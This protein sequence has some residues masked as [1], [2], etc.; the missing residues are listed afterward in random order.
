MST[1]YHYPSQLELI[2]YPHPV[3]RKEA[4]PVEV[5][6]DDLAAFCKRMLAAMHEYKGVGLAAPQVGVSKQIFVSDHAGLLGDPDAPSA[7]QV[8][9]NPRMEEPSGCT[10]YEEGC[11]SFPGIYA[12]V[13]RMDAFTAVWQDLEGKEHRKELNATTDV[14]GIVFQHELDHLHSKLFVDY[15]NPTQLTMVR[16]RLKD[17]EKAYKKATGKVGS[18]L[19]R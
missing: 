3:L 17:M 2:T 7:E 18:I 14:L 9:I 16:R 8:W 5:F 12:K 19:R 4:A 13:E 6:D 15:L 1:P 11:L 10:T